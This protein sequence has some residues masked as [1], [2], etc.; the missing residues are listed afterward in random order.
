MENLIKM[1]ILV[2]TTSF[3]TWQCINK[4]IKYILLWWDISTCYNTVLIV[5][6]LPQTIN[7]LSHFINLAGGGG[8]G[9]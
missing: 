6:I 5:Y 9:H 3:Y 2:I 8:G 4:T 7:K 1:N